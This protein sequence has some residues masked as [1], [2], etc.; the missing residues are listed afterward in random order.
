MIRYCEGPGCHKSLPAD[1]PW[2]ARYCSTACRRRREQARRK[3]QRGFAS[4]T[5]PGKGAEAKNAFDRLRG[6][7]AL[8][9]WKPSP[10]ARGEDMP[11]I[12]EF[13]RRY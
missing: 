11:D 12:P 1:L 13:L 6:D 2:N 3:E 8:S 5:S 4:H 9:K 7:S 10:N